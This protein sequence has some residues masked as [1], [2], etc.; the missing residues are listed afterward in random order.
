[1]SIIQFLVGCENVDIVIGIP[2]SL[3]PDY[4][5][6]LQDAIITLMSMFHITNR[7]SR[8]GIV[9]YNEDASLHRSIGLDYT[10][11]DVQDS[12]Y[13]IQPSLSYGF[14]T[15]SAMRVAAD[16]AFTIYGGV[17]QSYP[18]VMIL[19]VPRFVHS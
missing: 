19:F 5:Y 10:L 16:H 4:L 8:I 18:K 7:L 15:A 11:Q 1:M 17:R 9:E 14:N 13:S 6:R 2:S 12:V 3:S